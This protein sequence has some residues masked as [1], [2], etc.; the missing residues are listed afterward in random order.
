MLGND[1]SIPVTDSSSDQGD[2]AVVRPVL[3]TEKL[4]ALRQL[5]PEGSGNFLRKLISIYLVSASESLNQIECAI[6]TSDSQVLK[7]AAHTLKSGA[8]NIGAETLALICQ[9]LE[10]CGDNYQ[11]DTISVLLIKLQQECRKVTVALEA[12]LEES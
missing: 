7:K 3:N 1:N 12:L 8:G 5:D 11:L 6:Q 4:N 9:Q 10:D 2:N